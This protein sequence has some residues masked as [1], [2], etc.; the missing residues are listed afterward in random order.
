MEY[1][2]RAWHKEANK[3]LK[4]SYNG[5]AFKWKQDRQPLEIMQWTGLT[6][7][8]GVEIYEGDVC[9]NGNYDAVI[10]FKDGAF[11]ANIRNESVCGDYDISMVVLEVI[12]NI[13]Q[14]EYK[15]LRGE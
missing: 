3:M 7:K 12:G 2:F 9:T 8:N 5:E 13:Y 11:I 6:D 4:E 14:E 15:H 1:K 10:E